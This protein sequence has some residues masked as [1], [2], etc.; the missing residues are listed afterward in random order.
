LIEGY[1]LENFRKYLRLA[2]ASFPLTAEYTVLSAQPLDLADVEIV[3]YEGG[4]LHMRFDALAMRT[5]DY[6][7]TPPYV[8]GPGLR[9]CDRAECTYSSEDFEGSGAS[10]LAEVDVKAPIQQLEP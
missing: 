10:I 5:S 4:V 8:C 2:Y 9:T 1:S 6:I 3:S 7:V